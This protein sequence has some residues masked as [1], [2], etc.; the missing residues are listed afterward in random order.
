MQWT[1]QKP[2]CHSEWVS[3][4]WVNECSALIASTKNEGHSND[5]FRLNSLLL[6]TD[7]VPKSY[8]SGIYQSEFH[9]LD[10]V[11]IMKELKKAKSLASDIAIHASILF[12][13]ALSQI[14]ALMY[15]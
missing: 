3:Q 15:Y 8:P 2:L 11:E 4:A 1:N 6:F 7:Y 10:I 14:N 5:G 9:Q 13:K 12:Y